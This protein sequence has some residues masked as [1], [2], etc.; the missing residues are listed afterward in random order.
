MTHWNWLLFTAQGISLKTEKCNIL[1]T[2]LSEH[3]PIVLSFE[4]KNKPSLSDG[5]INNTLIVQ[6][7]F[8]QLKILLI[9]FLTK[10]YKNVYRNN[11]YEGK[12]YRVLQ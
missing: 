5:S 12:V 1:T 8:K 7:N 6:K 2:N 9:V 4:L 11:L 10:C 3:N